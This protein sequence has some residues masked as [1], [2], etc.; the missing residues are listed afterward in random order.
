MKAKTDRLRVTRTQHRFLP[1]PQR[2]ILRPF[3]PG[4]EVFVDGRSRVGLVLDRILALPEEEIPA[5]WEEV[6]AAFSFRHRDLES[7]LEDHFRLV[8]RHIEDPEPL[9]PERER[10]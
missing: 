6:R 4:E 8:S 5:A 10:L 1:D 3:L 2:V 9:S 7:V